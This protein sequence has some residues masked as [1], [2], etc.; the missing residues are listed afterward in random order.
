MVR[1]CLGEII[2]WKN[3][4][5][6]KPLVL[7][8]ARQ[9]GKTWLMEAFA[10]KEF[11][12]HSVVVNLMRRQSLCRQLKDA[13]IDPASLIRLLQMSTGERIVPGETFLKNFS[14]S[15]T[16]RSLPLYAFRPWIQKWLFPR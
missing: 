1:E 4:R 14:T 13:D 6:R 12:G 15:R 10:K 2:K 7:M 8:G 16:V 11:P 9:V 3:S 5:K